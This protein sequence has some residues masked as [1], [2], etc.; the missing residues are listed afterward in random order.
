MRDYAA[1]IP[2][3]T[4]MVYQLMFAIITPALI[5]GAFAERMRFSAMVL[6]SVLWL[7]IVYLPDGPHGLGQRRFAERV[8][9]RQHSLL[10]FRGRNG[11]PHHA[12]DVSALVCALY[13]GKRLG[14]PG[15][16]MKPHSLVLSFIGA[17]LLWVGWFGFNAGSALGARRSC[18][19]RLRRHAFRGGNRRPGLD[20]GGVDEAWQAKRAGRHLRRGRRTGRD[21][22]GFGIR[23]ADARAADRVSGR[24]DLLLHGGRSEEQV[25]I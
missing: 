11:C 9:R 8:S 1:T 3:Q 15:E 24:A 2:Q 4:F 17:C 25:R 19:Q 10:R 20:G 16:A 5:T 14:Y 18:N 12:R 21:Y 6:F 7:F 23:H 22:A 13:L